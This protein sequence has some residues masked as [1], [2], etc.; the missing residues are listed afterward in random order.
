M[1]RGKLIEIDFKEHAIVLQDVQ[2]YE[3][4]MIGNQLN[5]LAKIL[6]QA[7]IIKVANLKLDQYI[8]HIDF[9]KL[10][11]NPTESIERTGG[12]A[13]ITNKGPYEELWVFFD[14]YSV[15][16]SISD[17]KDIISI[18]YDDQ[19]IILT[20]RIISANYGNHTYVIKTKE[21]LSQNQSNG[22]I[23]KYY[24]YI[25]YAKYSGKDNVKIIC[26]KGTDES[27]EPIGQYWVID[28]QVVR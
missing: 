24:G 16:S 23:F 17:V 28:G 21:N 4:K 13:P 1:V 27:Q 22:I 7:N 5:P 20:G 14:T 15:G 2:I 8:M 26:I 6:S 12:W 25:E 19:L 10:S 9:T 3:C 11:P 18:G